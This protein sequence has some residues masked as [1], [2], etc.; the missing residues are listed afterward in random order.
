MKKIEFFPFSA[1]TYKVDKGLLN[2]T[3]WGVTYEHP[4]PMF[5]FRHPRGVVIFD[6]GINHRG[7]ENPV[8]WWGSS[9]DNLE[10]QAKKEDCLPFQ[11]QKVGID[12]QEV[13]YIIMSHLHIDHAGEMESFPHATFVVRHSELSFA[14]WPDPHMRFTYA[15]QD[16]KNTR[17]FDYLEI[18]DFIDFDL[19][20]D[21]SLVTIHTP[22]H[23]PGHQSLMVRLS[24]NEQPF[25]LC[26]DACY[27]RENLDGKIYSSNLLWNIQRWFET[28]RKLRYYQD[29][30]YDLWMGHELED[31]KKHLV[32]CD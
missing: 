32:P 2:N 18:P 25:I 31:W 26:Q 24:E 12:P 20:K 10:I 21:G 9:V 29:L 28:I 1:G 14:W 4:L 13:K 22:G 3:D 19:F 30:G 8:I 6:T 23:T 7:L 27:M 17:C 11:L 16:L 5:A 15:F